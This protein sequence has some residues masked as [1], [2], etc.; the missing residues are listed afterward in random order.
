MRRRRPDS[1]SAYEIAVRA[2]AKAWTAFDKSDR[3]LCDQAI[4]DAQA[5][6]AIDPDSTIALIAS[7]LSHYHHL[8]RGTAVDRGT[9]WREGMAAAARSIEVDR[10]EG[11]AH[12]LKGL[13]LALMPDRTRTGEM[14]DSARRGHGLN[15]HDM[16]SLFGLAYVECVAG[17]PEQAIEHLQQALRVSP[18]DPLRPN[19]QLQLARDHLLARQYAE[20]VACAV[21]GIDEAPVYPAL[22]IWLAA[23]YVGLGEF[24]RARA[25]LAKARSIAPEFV[26]NFVAGDAPYRNPEHLRRVTTSLRIAAGL[27]DP[28]AA[29]ALR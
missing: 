3:V 23:N 13:L 20:G 17:N 15:P 18:R 28:S 2:S 25:A 7:A 27:E 11:Y 19:I 16:R 21:R 24:K 6:L 12:V 5:A 22:H 1:L 8:I 29:E 14:L 4:E 10:A 9:A 26:E